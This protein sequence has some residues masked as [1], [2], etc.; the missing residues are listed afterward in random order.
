MIFNALP[1]AKTGGF[2][3]HVRRE[4]IAPDT[5]NLQLCVDIFI[6]DCGPG[7]SRLLERIIFRNAKCGEI[8]CMDV[9]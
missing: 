5:E 7:S 3:V 1:R 2:L 4:R 6:V 8:L 9:P